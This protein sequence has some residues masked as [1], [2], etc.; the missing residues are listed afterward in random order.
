[1]PTNFQI[2]SNKFSNHQLNH[3]IVTE[4]LIT[5]FADFYSL[6]LPTC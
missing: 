5:F 4:T 3:F 6:R 1:M 2:I